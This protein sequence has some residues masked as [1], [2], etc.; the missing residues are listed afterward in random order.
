MCR[1]AAAPTGLGRTR[2]RGEVRLLSSLYISE[3]ASV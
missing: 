2:E 3:S 1:T